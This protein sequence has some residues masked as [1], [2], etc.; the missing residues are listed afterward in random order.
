[1]SVWRKCS[2]NKE[3]SF[4]GLALRAGKLSVNKIVYDRIRAKKAKLVIA[5]NDASQRTKKQLSDKCAYYEIPYMSALESMEVSQSLGR[6][7]VKYLS[8]DD[9]GMAD[10]FLRIMKNRNEVE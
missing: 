8:I 4:L 2:L 1:M 7:N 3:I 5:T 9:Q 10:A 6:N